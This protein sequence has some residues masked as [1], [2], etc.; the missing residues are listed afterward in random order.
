MINNMQSTQPK[1]ICGGICNAKH[2]KLHAMCLNNPFCTGTSGICKEPRGIH[3]TSPQ[4]SVR[5]KAGP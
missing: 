3:A 5:T 1:L 2:A 4:F